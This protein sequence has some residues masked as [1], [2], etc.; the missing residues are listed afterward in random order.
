MDPRAMRAYPRGIL[1]PREYEPR[2]AAPTTPAA[3]YPTPDPH[4]TIEQYKRFHHLDVADMDDVTLMR[5]RARAHLRWVNEELG[6]YPSWLDERL[7]RLDAEVE[8]RSRRR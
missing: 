3:S 8:R 4:A 6:A 5:E 7:R 2:R 1:E